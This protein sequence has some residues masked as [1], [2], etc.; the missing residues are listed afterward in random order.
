M[1]MEGDGLRSVEVVLIGRARAS[2]A[3]LAEGLV[4]TARAAESAVAA[5]Q[6]RLKQPRGYRR[7]QD[8][9]MGRRTPVSA[10]SDGTDETL[11]SV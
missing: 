7:S 9:A 5:V 1:R 6:A 2:D 3:R 8:S 11:E 10:E 4:R